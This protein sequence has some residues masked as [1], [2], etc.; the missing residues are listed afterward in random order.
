MIAANTLLE[1]ELKFRHAATDA[2]I[3][4]LTKWGASE[5]ESRREVDHYYNAPDRD[6]AQTN[7]AFRIRVV[8]GVGTLTYK[9]PRQPGRAKTRREI[10]VPLGIQA[11]TVPHAQALV[12]SLGYRLVATLSK[13]R[14]VRTF[15]RGE[16]EFTACFDDVERVGRFVEIEIITDEQSKTEAEIVLLEVCHSLGLANPE[17]RS[18]L[19]MF[20][21]GQS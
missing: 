16:F 6:F 8:N 1:I 14:I 2:A 11:S 3:A 15:L 20:L 17:P 5:P 9:G 19:R 21:E 12:E 7:E 18:Y 10:E 13:S 4:I